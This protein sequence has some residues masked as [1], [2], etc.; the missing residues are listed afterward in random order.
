[1]V[2]G[3]AVDLVVGVLEWREAETSCRHISMDVR[4]LVCFGDGI[5]VFPSPVMV[6]DGV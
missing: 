5:F 3:E 1:V 6:L 2:R 4:D